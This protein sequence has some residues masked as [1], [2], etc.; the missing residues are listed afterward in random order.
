MNTSVCLSVTAIMLHKIKLEIRDFTSS[1]R[2]PM[3]CDKNG[4]ICVS[5]GIAA[6]CFADNT[7]QAVS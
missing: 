1:F 7:K 6:S 4:G 2:M 5:V 3:R